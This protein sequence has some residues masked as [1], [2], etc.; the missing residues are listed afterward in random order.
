MALT[1]TRPA[2]P[3]SAAVMTSPIPTR[4]RR[5]AGDSGRGGWATH[6]RNSRRRTSALQVAQ[7]GQDPTVAGVGRGQP[8]LGEDAAGVL[9]D[10]ALAH[11]QGGGAGGSGPA[12]GH[13]LERLPPPL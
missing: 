4:P 12:L 6:D 5:P 3:T 10:R 13:E 8:E 1:A 9:L 2:A 7:H 11:H